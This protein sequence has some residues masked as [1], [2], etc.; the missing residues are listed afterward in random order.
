MPKKKKSIATKKSGI[1]NKKKLVK[2]KSSPRS[3]SVSVAKGVKI[4]VE[5]KAKLER[6]KGSSN[7]GE[8][9]RV[10]PVNFA[11][12]AGGASPYSFPINTMK[13]AKSALARA[14]FAPNPEGIVR[15]VYKKFPSLNPKNKK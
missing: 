7:T 10:S 14:H 3:K 15:A 12:S 8:Y 5:K 2:K 9:S 1:A 6:K 4:P 13:R 11:G